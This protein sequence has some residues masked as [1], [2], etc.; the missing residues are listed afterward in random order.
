MRSDV[1]AGSQLPSQSLGL[2]LPL[3]KNTCSFISTRNT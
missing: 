3:D 2:A 1:P